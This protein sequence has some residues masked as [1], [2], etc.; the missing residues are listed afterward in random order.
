MA[1]PSIPPP[2]APH[3]PSD[4][5]EQWLARQALAGHDRMWLQRNRPALKQRWQS[6]P[7]TELPPPPPRDPGKVPD[8]YSE[9]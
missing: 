7:N 4:P 8:R 9:L 2:L 3:F 1:N 5:F 6:D